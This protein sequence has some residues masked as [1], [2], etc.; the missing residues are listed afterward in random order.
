[1]LRFHLILF[2]FSY[3]ALSAT[4]VSAA[5]PLSSASVLTEGSVAVAGV[6]VSK[7]SDSKQ[8]ILRV[9]AKAEFFAGESL[10]VFLR[11]GD[12]SIY[13]AGDR[14]RADL[15][16]RAAALEL[17]S[18]WP[19]GSN[20]RGILQSLN[21]RLRLDTSSRG[22][23][24]FR[25][26]GEFL[27][28]F[29]LVN[30]RGGITQSASL[31]GHYVVMNF[32]F[33]RCMVATMCPLSTQKMR[34]LRSDLSEQSELDVKLVSISLDP[35]YDTPGVFHEYAAAYGFPAEGIDFLSGPAQAVEDLKAQLGVLAQP[36]EKLVVKHTLMVVVADP[37]GKIIYE[38]PGSGWSSQ[39]ILNKIVNH[40]QS[41]NHAR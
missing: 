18:V 16:A 27:P 20:E 40:A 33:S 3:A 4:P 24:P 19:D 25:S 1:M 30:Q 12:F 34:S 22:K 9:D 35:S 41:S 23:F 2:L 38:I 13:K 17:A 36:D 28:P 14:I 29:A 32:I 39:D 15:R 31:H 37:L 5:A 26:T 21:H 7:D 6:I 10:R 11:D 8:V